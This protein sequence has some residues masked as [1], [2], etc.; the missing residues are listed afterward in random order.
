ME[1][2]GSDP[3][4]IQLDFLDEELHVRS[5]VCRTETKETITCFKI[6]T[7]RMQ[8][9]SEKPFKI[10]FKAVPGITQFTKESSQLL[11]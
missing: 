6:V 2:N 5:L 7:E 4:E 9:P 10:F 3:Q 8:V 11:P 1:F